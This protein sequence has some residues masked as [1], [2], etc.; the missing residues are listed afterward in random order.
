VEQHWPL[1]HW[2]GENRFPVIDDA[3]RL[4]LECFYFGIG[5]DMATFDEAIGM[6]LFN[7]LGC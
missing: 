2:R 6:E 1:A 3:Q 4:S 5:Q 7:L